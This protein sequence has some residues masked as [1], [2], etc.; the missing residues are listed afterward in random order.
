MTLRVAALNGQHGEPKDTW[1][2]MLQRA[3]S[4][5]PESGSTIGNDAALCA[6]AQSRFKRD[7]PCG[8]DRVT[9]ASSG[10]EF[11][12]SILPRLYSVL[13]GFICPD[14]TAV[15]AKAQREFTVVL[16]LLVVPQTT[17]CAARRRRERI[18]PPQLQ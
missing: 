8:Y 11:R 12:P 5:A 18:P 17:A 6:L 3:G 10:R 14:I 9:A 13:L 1:V 4:P 16:W 7:N 15:R 2:W